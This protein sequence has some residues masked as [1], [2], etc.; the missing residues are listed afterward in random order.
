MYI[1]ISQNGATEIQRYKD[2]EN[3][4]KKK[5]K[6]KKLMER[7]IISVYEV[8]VEFLDTLQM[9]SICKV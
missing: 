1:Y 6:N 4:N 7:L 5:N 8:Y 3:K 9:S 2:K